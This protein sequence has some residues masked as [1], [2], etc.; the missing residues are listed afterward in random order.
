[1]RVQRADY[2]VRIWKRSPD[3]SVKLT[4]AAVYATDVA[5]I[6]ALKELQYERPEEYMREV[7]FLLPAQVVP[8]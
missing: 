5:A 6:D 1:M 4:S 3:G 8:L 7:F 2:P